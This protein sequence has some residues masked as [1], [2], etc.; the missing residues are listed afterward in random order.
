[1]HDDVDSDRGPE[2]S[3]QHGGQDFID[4]PE[5]DGATR[6]GLRHGTAYGRRAH[7]E[8]AAAVRTRTALS[9]LAKQIQFATER[10]E[11]GAHGVG[12]VAHAHGEATSIA[13]GMCRGG[14]VGSQMLG[15]RAISGLVA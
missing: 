2:G 9:A 8:G 3:Q 5:R 6:V 13:L 10:A 11:N 7:G 1:M 15:K 4:E 14:I 12:A